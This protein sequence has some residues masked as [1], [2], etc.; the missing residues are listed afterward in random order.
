MIEYK[1]PYRETQTYPHKH[2]ERSYFSH[3]L[4]HYQ[5]GPNGFNLK[6]NKEFVAIGIIYI[7]F[8]LISLIRGTRLCKTKIRKFILVL[9]KGGRGTRVV[10]GP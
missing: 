6:R 1:V 5:E 9:V 8:N 2:L 3:P 4:R 10:I 7:L